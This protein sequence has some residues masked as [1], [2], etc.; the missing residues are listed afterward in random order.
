M[1]DFLKVHYEIGDF[2]VSGV[3]STQRHLFDRIIN[4]A[5]KALEYQN[6]KKRLITS[7]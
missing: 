4:I 6:A 5:K 1:I 2:V 3:L 7:A